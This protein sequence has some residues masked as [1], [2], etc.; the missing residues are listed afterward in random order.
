M[1]RHGRRGLDLSA[2]GDE[3]PASR[4]RRDAACAE[5]DRSGAR[6]TSPPVRVLAPA[7]RHGR[8]QRDRRVRPPLEGTL[9]FS[10]PFPP[11]SGQARLPS[12]ANARALIQRLFTRNSSRCWVLEKTDTQFNTRNAGG[13]RFFKRFFRPNPGNTLA[14]GLAEWLAM[15]QLRSTSARPQ[16][17]TPE[18][19]ASAM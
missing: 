14:Q 5:S 13:F 3:I 10:Y 19:K 4:R 8:D 7:V 2:V 1:D 12:K 11:R 9:V 15:Q 6:T 16:T 17:S 18:G